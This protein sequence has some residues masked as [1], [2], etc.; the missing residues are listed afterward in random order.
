MKQVFQRIDPSK[1]KNHPLNH[2]L[3]GDTPSDEF[4]E[5][6]KDGIHDPLL[7]LPSLTVI[8][9]HKRRQA[10]IIHKHKEVTIV[11]RHDWEKLD[12]LEIERLIITLNKGRDKTVEQRAREFKR[13]EEIEAEFAARREKA[14]K[15]P[16]ADTLGQKN[17]R[18]GKASEIAAETVGLARTTAVKAAEV[19]EKIDELKAEGKTEEAAALAGTLEKNVSAAHRTATEAEDKPVLDG[20]DRPVPKNLVPT[21]EAR[22]LFKSALAKLK[23]VVADVGKLGDAGRLINQPSLKRDIDNARRAIR[24][25]M[26]HA[27]CPYCQAKKADC[28]ACKGS[29]WV[30]ED[31]YSQAPKEMKSA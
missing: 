2:K 15:K 27:V 25:A 29:G 20:L 30:G 11:V 16:G 5:A 8:S 10:A 17:P 31:T 3:Y 26:P 6:T 24:F 19:V 14:G 4:L 21:F 9:G 13:L 1:L 28:K 18:V 22:K 12:P 7:V 23:G